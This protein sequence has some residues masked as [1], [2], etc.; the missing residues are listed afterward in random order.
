[1]SRTL[2]PP[3]LENGPDS[4]FTV[5]RWGSASDDEAPRTDVPRNGGT[6]ADPGANILGI[7]TIHRRCKETALTTG[8]IGGVLQATQRGP[9]AEEF[10]PTTSST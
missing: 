6:G 10:R 3:H 9:Q 4:T 1:M 8:G 7:S 2:P 5:A